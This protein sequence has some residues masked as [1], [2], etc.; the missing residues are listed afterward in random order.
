MLNTINKS[1]II[2]EK[3]YSNTK[4]KYTMSNNSLVIYMAYQY[5]VDVQGN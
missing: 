4:N 1:I 2:I 5:Q 3:R